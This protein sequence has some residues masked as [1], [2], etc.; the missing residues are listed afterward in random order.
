MAVDGKRWVSFPQRKWTEVSVDYIGP[1]K[2]DLEGYTGTQ[3]M[4][5]EFEKKLKDK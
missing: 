2:S 4:I 5:D 1:L 3:D